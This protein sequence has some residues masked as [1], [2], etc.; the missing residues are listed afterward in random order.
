[1]DF[2]DH[3]KLAGMH[4]FLSASNYHWVN[5]DP[6]KLLRVYGNSEAAKRGTELHAFAA[7]AIRLRQRLRGNSSSLAQYV[8]DGIGYRMTPEQVLFVS[9]FCFGTPDT[10]SFYGGA[11]RIH[12]FKSGVSAPASMMQLRI[13]AAMFCIE[14]R[15]DPRT[16]EMEFRIYQF[17]ETVIEIGDPKE[18]RDIM[19]KIRNFTTI[20]EGVEDVA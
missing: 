3:S 6:E 19:E 4:A 11:L 10:I 5:Y 16:I 1:M 14:Y 7:E 17:D 8:N 20:L 18:I 15:L 12:D 9:R 2:N 13:Y